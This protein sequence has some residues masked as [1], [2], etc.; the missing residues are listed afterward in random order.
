MSYKEFFFWGF[1]GAVIVIGLICVGLAMLI[2]AFEKDAALLFGVALFV[3]VFITP[4][5]LYL[6]QQIER[7]EKYDERRQKWS[8]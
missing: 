8:A 3:I 6:G 2:H 1:G 5:V 4:A 7:K